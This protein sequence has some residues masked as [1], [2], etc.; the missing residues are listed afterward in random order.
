MRIIV[1]IASAV[2]EIDFF[3]AGSDTRTNTRPLVETRGTTGL[4]RQRQGC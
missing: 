1:I 3:S 2:K 4:A